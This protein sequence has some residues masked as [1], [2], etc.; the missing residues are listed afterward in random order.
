M[1][2]LDELDEIVGEGWL[3]AIRRDTKFPEN[4]ILTGGTDARRRRILERSI[5][6]LHRDPDGPH[7]AVVVETEGNGHS[8][9][10]F[11]EQAVEKVAK[12]TH[13]RKAAERA[14]QGIGRKNEICDGSDYAREGLAWGTLEAAGEAEGGQVIVVVPDFWRTLGGLKGGPDARWKLRGVLQRQRRITLWTAADDE[15]LLM[16]DPGEALYQ[17]L[18][19]VRLTEEDR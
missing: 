6:V 4:Q 17:G 1:R 12:H 19:I 15:G 16:W 9:S 14:R 18:R 3:D 5:E 13:R 7:T 11:W 2:T 8:L 10:E